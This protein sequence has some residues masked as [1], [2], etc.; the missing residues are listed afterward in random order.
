[1]AEP[2]SAVTGWP[3]DGTVV[4][5]VRQSDEGGRFYRDVTEYRVIRRPEPDPQP[6]SIALTLGELQE[7][8][9]EGG[10]LTNEARSALSLL[11]PWL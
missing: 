7:L 5:R 4:A 3:V 10:W 2:G 9:L 11:L 1:V 6:N 8:L